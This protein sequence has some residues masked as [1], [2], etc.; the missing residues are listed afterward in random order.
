M[1]A[2]RTP[3]ADSRHDGVA[4]HSGP[5]TP[6]SDLAADAR[7]ADA[8]R[9]LVPATLTQSTPNA[10]A[11][12]VRVRGLRLTIEAGA[13]AGHTWSSLGDSCTIGS[14]PRCDLVIDDPTVSR[15][16]CDVRIGEDRAVLRTHA[17]I[18]CGEVPVAA[19]R[20]GWIYCKK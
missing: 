6:I 13:Q 2:G 17:L 1:P 11:D 20:V 15:F 7:D 14:H 18:H 19:R 10:S 5:G 12:V 9:A 3:S 8:P 4:D 16:H